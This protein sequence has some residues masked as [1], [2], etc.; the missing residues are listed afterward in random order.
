MR[1]SPII[2]S[3]RQWLAAQPQVRFLLLAAGF[4]A[5]WVL[6]YEHGLERAG[7]LDEA[8]CCN[9]AAAVAGLLRLVGVTAGT[10]P[11]GPTTVTMFGQAAV[12]VGNPCNGLVLYALFTGFVLAYPG[13]GRRRL[14][15]IPLGLAAIYGINVLRIALLAINHTYWYHTVEFNHHYTFTFVA[16]GVILVL[17]HQWV[18]PQVLPAT[19][20]HG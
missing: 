19:V 12:Y 1:Y 17:W 16:Y 18:R 7:H 6:G 9:L 10:D 3:D 2:D 4:Y 15:F 20:A 8:L 5:L 11:A 14:W 13:S